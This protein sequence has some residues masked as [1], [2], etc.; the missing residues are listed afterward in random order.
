MTSDTPVNDQGTK[1]TAENICFRIIYI[2]EPYN[3]S[4]LGAIIL[5][6]AGTPLW[7]NFLEN[8]KLHHGLLWPTTKQRAALTQIDF[9]MHY[10]G[11][12][13]PVGST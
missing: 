3:G 7:R 8:S 13:I 6:L 2:S 4:R 1:E 11:G 5:E 10:N 12:T 9:L